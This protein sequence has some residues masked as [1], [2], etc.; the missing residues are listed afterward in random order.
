MEFALARVWQ[1]VRKFLPDKCIWRSMAP[2][3]PLPV[4]FVEPAIAG[5]DDVM[6]VISGAEANALRLEV[7]TVPMK[8]VMQWNIAHLIS[9]A[10]SWKGICHTSRKRVN[11][12]AFLFTLYSR[13][14]RTG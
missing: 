5:D 6:T 2:A 4:L 13:R 9:K 12:S 1:L 14:R 8:Q 11:L 10:V 3:P 7:K